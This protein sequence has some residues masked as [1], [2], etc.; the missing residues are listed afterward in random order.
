MKSPAPTG[1]IFTVQRMV[2]GTLRNYT[3]VARNAADA[4]RKANDA[5]A[6]DRGAA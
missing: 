1:N 4:A 3:V 6:H 5:A 2:G